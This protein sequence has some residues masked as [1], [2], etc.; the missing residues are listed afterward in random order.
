MAKLTS[1][2]RSLVLVM[3]SLTA[4]A[5]AARAQ[6]GGEAQASPQ[7]ASDTSGRVQ[8]IVVTAQRREES[9]QRV[10]IAIST[11]SGAALENTGVLK[12]EQLA[13]ATPGLVLVQSRNS[14]TPYIRGIGTQ[15]G[16]PGDEGSVGIYVD[17]VLMPSTGAN[18][19]SLN[20]IKR[21]EVLKGPQGTL[22]GRNTTA[23]VVNV[24]TKD[25][26]HR[27]SVDASIGYSSYDTMTAN[28]YATTGLGEGVATD[29]ALFVQDQGRGWGRNITRGNDVDFDDSFAVRSKTLFDFSGNFSLTLAG[30]YSWSRSDLGNSRGLLP[31]TAAVGGFLASNLGSF[32]NTAGNLGVDVNRTEIYGGSAV[33]RA[34]LSWATLTSTTAYRHYRVE[35]EY[36][37][38]GTPLAAAQSFPFESTRAIQQEFLLNGTAGKLDWTAG[39][40]YFNSNAGWDPITLQ[41]AL[42]AGT[43]SV[44]QDVM[45]TRSYAG[46]AQGTYHFGN[47]TSLTL[48]GRYTLDKRTIE[49]TQV[50]GPGNTLAVGTLINS[51]A[52]LPTSQTNRE[53]DAFTYRAALDHQFTDSVLGYASATRGFKSGVFSTTAPFAPAVN[54]ET[55]LAYELG[56]KSDLFDRRLRVNVAAFYNDYKNIQLN[57]VQV[58]G[59]TLATV[60]LNAAA[61]RVKGV[62]LEVSAVPDVGFGHLVISGGLTALDAKYRSFPNAQILTAR[63]LTVGGNIQT[64]G[65]ATGNR[66]IQAP[67]IVSSLSV[68]YTLPIGGRE[69]NLNGLWSHNSGFFFDPQNRFAQ[70]AYD[71]INAQVGLK[72]SE[73]VRVRAF[74]RNMLDEKYYTGVSGSTLA[75]LYGPGAP[76]TFGAAVDFSLGK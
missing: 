49:G 53:F 12:I 59:T 58:V 42:S 7:S 35:T 55:V 73:Q 27:T 4:T 39:L 13:A 45:R 48:G 75:V 66:L 44:I 6:S 31:G 9:L 76:R 46:F 19:F 1:A 8:D 56:V 30:D 38:D 57:S 43:N 51:T 37:Q 15:N 17:G 14:L 29:I 24:I 22:F 16:A 25:P 65:D 11:V 10:P 47:G 32:Y 67:R 74:V 70:P 61:G 3:T 62:E 69:I 33:I 34:D 21:I 5:A 63:P 71:L 64:F 50:A 52:R 2:G 60:L 26:S 54:P 72:L 36:D 40:F 28:A 18:T 68:D 23:G 41:S 20:N